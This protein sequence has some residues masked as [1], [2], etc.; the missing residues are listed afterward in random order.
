MSNPTERSIE[1]R[2]DRV[3]GDFAEL[4]PFAQVSRRRFLAGAGVAAVSAT[5][6]GTGVGL[7]QLI[8]AE[9]AGLNLPA[10]LSE[11]AR[12]AAILE[13]LPG[14]RSLIKLSYRPP[15]YETPIEYFRTAITPNDA[16]FVRYRLAIIPEVDATTWKIVVGGDGAIGQ[17]EITL[18]DLKT[19]PAH[20]VVAVNQCSGN[21]RGLFQPHVTGVAWG[22]GAMGCARWKGAKLKDCST[23][24]V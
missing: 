18:S 14:K 11:G 20:E 12:A 13:K 23:K 8:E 2:K 9:A 19:M 22:Y 16:F 4:Q 3:H 10:E 17:A 5:L 24:L 6:G 15:Y 21:R 7:P 1:N